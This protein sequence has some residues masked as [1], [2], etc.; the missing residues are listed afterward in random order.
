MIYK[1]QTYFKHINEFIVLL[2]FLYQ[3]VLIVQQLS[4]GGL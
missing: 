4:C 1:T 2:Y 3:Q